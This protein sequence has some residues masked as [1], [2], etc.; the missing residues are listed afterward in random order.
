MCA[1]SK[2]REKLKDKH[3]S[4]TFFASTFKFDFTIYPLRRNWGKNIKLIGDELEYTV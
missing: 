1:W 2:E 3:I 4:E